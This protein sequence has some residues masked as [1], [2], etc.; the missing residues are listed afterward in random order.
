MRDER[1]RDDFVMTTQIKIKMMLKRKTRRNEGF[2]IYR[3]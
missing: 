3:N 1:R 2:F